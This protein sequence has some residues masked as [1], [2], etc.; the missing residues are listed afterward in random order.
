MDGYQSL[1]AFLPPKT[2]RGLILID[3]PFED[4]DE[5]KKILNALRLTKKRFPTGTYAI[6]YPVKNKTTVKNFQE[7]LKLLGFDNILFTEFFTAKGLGSPGLTACG[8][9]IINAPWKFEAKLRSITTWL[10]NQ[11]GKH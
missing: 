1:K 10:Y 7:E 6:W 4:K 8:I 3:P 2:G 9:A 11:V 5:F